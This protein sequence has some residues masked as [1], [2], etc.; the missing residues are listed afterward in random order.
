M[1]VLF[2]IAGMMKLDVYE[3]SYA[4]AKLLLVS[5]RNFGY[6][7]TCSLC[8]LLLRLNVCMDVKDAW[9]MAGCI[10]RLYVPGF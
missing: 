2:V 9:E 3:N 1:N 4:K 7:A 6:D 10:R 5:A 8:G